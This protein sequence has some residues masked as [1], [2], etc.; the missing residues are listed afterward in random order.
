VFDS[1]KSPYLYLFENIWYTADRP[2]NIF[3][4]FFYFTGIFWFLLVWNTFFYIYSNLKKNYIFE[5]L[6]L[7]LIFLF[8][9]F[10]SI[11]TY[12]IFIIL[13][14]LT[15]VKW[16]GENDP[17][18]SISRFRDWL[19]EK[20]KLLDNKKGGYKSLLIN[21]WFDYKY[22]FTVIFFFVITF[23]SILGWIINTNRY[24]GEVYAFKDDYEKSLKICKYNPVYYY[25]LWRF[26]EWLAMEKKE[27]VEYFVGKIE[28]GEDIEWD[29]NNFVKK[30]FVAETFFYCWD[31]FRSL[32]DDENAKKY[33]TNGIK[34]IP[35]LWNY[36][37]EYFRY[38]K[39]EKLRKSI[40]HRFF[41]KKYWLNKI[42]NRIGK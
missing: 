20:N 37:S 42:L 1:Y 15:F 34:L 12:L 26:E 11:W 38:I 14:G 16:N 6:F 21:N 8:F 24:F 3:I 31:V 9:N 25:K 35:D 13:L 33:Y 30:Y 23:I 19:N 2:H 41:S 27:W 40:L 10:A 18:F 5:S 39:D 22:I 29:C 17:E 7:F 36:N 4:N 28:N 32:W